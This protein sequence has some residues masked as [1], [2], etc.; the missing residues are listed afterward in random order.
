MTFPLK[1]T[2]AILTFLGILSALPRMSRD[3]RTVDR[4]I[5]ESVFDFPPERLSSADMLEDLVPHVADAKLVDPAG[6]LAHF[7]AALE[8]TERREPEAITRIVHYGDSPTTADLITGDAR[9]LLQQRF[10]NA[11]HGFSFIAK[12]WD[13]YEHR[14]IGLNAT[15]WD[16]AAASQG[17][18]YDGLYG[19]GGGSFQ[20]AGDA[21]SRLV[22][23]DPSHSSAE[24]EYLKQRGGG[25]F[26]IAVDG[27]FLARVAT[28]APARAAGFARFA[29]PAAGARTV[30]I[31]AYGAVRIFG[32]VFDKPGP[33]VSY[34][35]LGMNGAS[36]TVLG[37]AF[38][39]RHW[40]EQLQHRQPDLVVV[41]YGTNES[42][43][44]S[45]IANSYEQEIRLVV[46]RIRKA[47]PG[48]S[49]L[50]M[51]PMDRGTRVA[52]GNTVTL[53][54]IPKIVA[55]QE[56]V[57]R[58]SGCAFF[59]TFAAMGGEGTM[60][61]WY[62]AHPRMVA[63]DFIHPSPAG[64]KLVGNLLYQA[65]CDGFTKYKL[66]RMRE[67]YIVVSKKRS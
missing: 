29:L 56:R 22:L 62:E 33:G 36:I 7:Y 5:M 30:E 41:N 21:Y 46:E 20:N 25:T 19:L 6:D 2:L 54:T 48:V 3:L 42:G 49:V 12:P 1:P 10:G 64:A 13:W 8:H 18:A 24:V 61:K 15:G 32:I 27:K 23:K 65:L 45:F 43:F 38:N 37:H 34:D 67:K 53:S 66:K 59:N 28:E 51:S 55:V 44:A 39:E 16:I 52:G 40:A 9:Q 11:G 17:G 63:A 4:E 47:V 57:A 31:R 35:S 60:A 14:N 50:L 58:E 26:T